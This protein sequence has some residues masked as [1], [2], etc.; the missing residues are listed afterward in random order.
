MILRIFL[1]KSWRERLRSRKSLEGL[2]GTAIIATLILIAFVVTIRIVEGGTWFDAVWL[3]WQTATTVG[4][5]DDTPS[6][7]AGQIAAM[8]GGIGLI[9][10]LTKVLSIVIEWYG[11]QQTLRRLGFM[12]SPQTGGYVLIN[13]PGAGILQQ[14]IEQIRAREPDIG[15][16]VVDAEITELPEEI[17]V[18]PSIHYVRGRVFDEAT[19]EQAKIA[20]CKKVVVFPRDASS[21]DGDAITAEIV[22]GLR[23]YAGSSLDIIALVIDDTH[24]PMFAR[25]N[26]SIVLMNSPI[27]AAVQECQ[28]TGSAAAIQRMLSNTDGGDLRSFVPPKGMIGMTWGDFRL[29]VATSGFRV[30][31]LCIESPDN[32]GDMI[33]NLCPENTTRIESSDRIILVVLGELDWEDFKQKIF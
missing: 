18:L 31:P 14:F 10:L 24:K 33:P 5:G 17:A 9:V 32:N 20:S 16:C 15:I 21:V 28:D 19:Y 22:R 7:V 29:R 26:I 30:N 25:T 1:V 8:L 11:E 2:I 6:T 4:F 23:R 3:A 12:E 13:F 27:L